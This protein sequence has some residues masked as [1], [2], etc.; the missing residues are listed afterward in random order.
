MGYWIFMVWNWRENYIKKMRKRKILTMDKA[1]DI[2][3]DDV[4]IFLNEK[5]TPQHIMGYVKTKTNIRPS[6]IG[7][8]QLFWSNKMND[9]HCELET[10]KLMPN[11]KTSN[12]MFRHKQEYIDF[13]EHCGKTKDMIFAL[14][15]HLGKQ[16]EKFIDKA[17][18]HKKDN[19]SKC[20]IP[21]MIIP[22]RKFRKKIDIVESRIQWMFNHIFFCRRCDITNNNDRVTL[23]TVCRYNIEYMELTDPD[24][25]R[26]LI[27]AYYSLRYYKS[28]H[29]KKRNMIVMRIKQNGDVYNDCYCIA[30]KL[31]HAM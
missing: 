24:V 1:R 25:I 28:D 2:Q 13:S 3:I 19:R 12:K 27:D 18:R 23:D 7:E 9:Y 15:E 5:Q 20:M 11:I 14:P 21:I 8:H 10:V 29:I 30:G 6:I 26:H 17:I 4:V 22:C 16:I 31:E